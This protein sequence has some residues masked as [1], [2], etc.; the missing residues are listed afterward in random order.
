MTS[1]ALFKHDMQ[2]TS[3][4]AFH[5]LPACPLTVL[6]VFAKPDEKT[7]QLRALSSHQVAKELGWEICSVSGRI[8]DLREKFGFLEFDSIQVRPNGCSEKLWRMTKAGRFWLAD[9]GSG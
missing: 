8:T 6:R 1:Q 4:D 5:K 2:L 3:L 7:G 9:H